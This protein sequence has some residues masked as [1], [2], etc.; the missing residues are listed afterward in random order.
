[1][2]MKMYEEAAIGPS[3]K[4]HQPTEQPTQMRMR[5]QALLI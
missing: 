3:R 5:K 1:M 4:K 2:K